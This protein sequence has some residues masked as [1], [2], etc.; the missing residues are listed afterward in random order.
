MWFLCLSEEPVTFALYIINTLVFITEVESVYCA[1]RTESLHK[2]DT[3]RHQGVIH[4]NFTR[5][6]S[7]DSLLDVISDSARSADKEF[8]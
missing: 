7:C 2:T 6:I 5:T 4:S 1:V 8:P 3:I